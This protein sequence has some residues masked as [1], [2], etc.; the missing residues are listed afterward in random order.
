MVGIDGQEEHHGHE[1]LEL[2]DYRYL[3]HSHWVHKLG[4]GKT[5]LKGNDLS[6][7]IDANKKKPHK[8]TD[9]KADEHFLNDQ[10]KKL[11]RIIPKDQVAAD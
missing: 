11:I 6:R 4:K 7:S 3:S 9:N 10:E 5:R 8:K 1:I 2:F